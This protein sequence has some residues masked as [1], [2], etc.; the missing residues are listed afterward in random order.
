M[1]DLYFIIVVLVSKRSQYFFHHCM[2]N[3]RIVEVVLSLKLLRLAD[4]KYSEGKPTELCDLGEI[5]SGSHFLQHCTYCDD[6]KMSIFSMKR[7]DKRTLNCNGCLTLVC[8]S[9]LS[10]EDEL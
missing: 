8:L 4:K 6:L 10:K 3:R 9:L 7:F 5:E 2:L 1:Q